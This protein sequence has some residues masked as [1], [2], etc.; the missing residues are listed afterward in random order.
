MDSRTLF[1]KASNY[2][3]P[4]FGISR[5]A[6]YWIIGSVSMLAVLLIWAVIASAQWLLFQGKD[7]AVDIINRAPKMSETV[8]GKVEQVMPGAKKAL[9][10]VIPKTREA[11]EGAVPGATGALE[12]VLD[13]LDS[14]R[15]TQREVSGAD[16]APVTRYDGLVRIAWDK[17]GIAQYEGK[18]DFKQVRH[19]YSKGFIEQG[20]SETIISANQETEIQEYLKGQDRYKLTTTQKSSSVVQLKIERMNAQSS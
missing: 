2:S 19:H 13:G 4:G 16:I 6:I 9:E 20:Y 8:L 18:A 17:A 11:L 1:S 14:K 7:A 3:R 5:K 12:G 15:S 10:D